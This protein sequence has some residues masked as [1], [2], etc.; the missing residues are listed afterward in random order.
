MLHSVEIGA[1]WQGGPH[2]T[3]DDGGI[4]SGVLPRSWVVR[5]GGPSRK[6]TERLSWS[7]VVPAAGNFGAPRWSRWAKAAR[8]AYFLCRGRGYGYRPSGDLRVGL[9]DEM[10]LPR[11][12]Q[13]E[14]IAMPAAKQE[15]YVS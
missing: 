6:R 5:G 3:S 10:P 1:D 13:A 11:G 2:Y 9:V 15:Q 4:G 8:V 7:E 14:Q 12:N